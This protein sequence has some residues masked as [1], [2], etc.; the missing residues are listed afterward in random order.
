MFLVNSIMIYWNIFTISFG[1]LIYSKLSC[2]KLRVKIL[3]LIS[4]IS[5]ESNTVSIP[6]IFTNIYVTSNY[7]IQTSEKCGNMI[8]SAATKENSWS[9]RQA[10]QIDSIRKENLIFTGFTMLPNSF[11]SRLG[12]INQTLQMWVSSVTMGFIYEMHA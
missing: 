2:I 12:I 3:T 11:Y 8:S 10:W 6:D 5:V 9:S 4:L 1:S 7:C